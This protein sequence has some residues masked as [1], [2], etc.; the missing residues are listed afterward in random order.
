MGLK[1][2]IRIGV[3]ILGMLGCAVAPAACDHASVVAPI[4]LPTQITECET[5]TARVCGTWSLVSGTRTYTAN[6]PQGS[7]ATITV[8]QF[9]AA[10]VVFNRTD[11]AG[12]T[13]D[14]NAHYVG[15]LSGASVRSGVVQ[16][17]T[18]GQTFSGTW[19]A[20]W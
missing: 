9:D 7:E 18:G 13:P 16:W 14:M 2:S 15:V 20:T 10:A 5:H 17:T 3:S 1:D 19:D 6:W 8:V 12:P 11:N 4:P